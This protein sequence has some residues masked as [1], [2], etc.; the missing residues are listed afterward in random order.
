WKPN[1]AII[2]SI[3]FGA[4]YIASSYITGISFANKELIKMLPYVVTI[5]VLIFTSIRNKKE[6]QPPQSLGLAYFREE[7]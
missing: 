4:L 5:V 2:G 6:N 7:R 1:L 3:I